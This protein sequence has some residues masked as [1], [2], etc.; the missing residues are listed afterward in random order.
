ML[1]VVIDTNQF[2]SSVINK[3]GPSANLLEA[4]RKY[5]FTLVL[6][7][8][9]V[10]EI[11]R[12][13]LY[14][15]ISQKYH[16]KEDDINAFLGFIEHEAVILSGLAPIDVIQDDPEDNEIVACA[17][18]AGADYIVSGDKHLLN[19]KNYQGITIVTVREFLKLIAYSYS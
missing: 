5:C 12:V 6:S 1:K 14:P 4:W 10:Q 3:H 7:D 19:L 8:K 18:E 2:I 11:R 16:L 9:V 15:R 17:L 13:F